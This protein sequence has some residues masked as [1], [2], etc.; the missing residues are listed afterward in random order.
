MWSSRGIWYNPVWIDYPIR[1]RILHPSWTLAFLH[2]S[3]WTFCPFFLDIFYCHSNFNSIRSIDFCTMELI[4]CHKWNKYFGENIYF[5]MYRIGSIKD[6][7]FY[8]SKWIFDPRLPYKKMHKKLCL[9][10]FLSGALMEPIRFVLS[11]DSFSIRTKWNSFQ[12][13]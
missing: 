13:P 7:G 8:F 9:A 1:D 11:C 5:P 12:Y 6:P 10:L 2:D 4:Q 3:F